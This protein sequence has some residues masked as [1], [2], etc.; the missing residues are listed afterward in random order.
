MISYSF[1]LSWGGNIKITTDQEKVDIRFWV[2]N[3][4][5]GVE[6]S[7]G[8]G[9]WIPLKQFSSFVALLE[10]LESEI[11]LWRERKV[12]AESH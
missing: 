7:T 9:F 6:T 1:P 4:D 10:N 11:V 12:N 5:T 2:A 3:K 8:R